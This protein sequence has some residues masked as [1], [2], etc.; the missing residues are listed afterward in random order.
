MQPHTEKMARRFK[1]DGQRHDRKRSPAAKAR[2]QE[3]R[4][5]RR[6]KREGH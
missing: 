3:R 2:T 4:A 6:M 5:I 1:S